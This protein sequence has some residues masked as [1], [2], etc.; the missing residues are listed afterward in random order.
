MELFLAPLDKVTNNWHYK[1][2]KS[3]LMVILTRLFNDFESARFLL[4][5]GFPEQAI[6]SMRDALECMMLFRLFS[7]DSKYAS[8]WSV[9]FKEYHI[10]I[11][12][13]FLD[14]LGVECPEYAFYGM[15]SEMVHPNLLSVASK[16]TEH[17]I[18]NTGMVR[19]YHFGGMNRP[20]WTT[21]VFNNLLVFILMTLLSVLSP[22]YATY[23]N[24]PE[25]W[26]SKVL[27]AR[28]KLKELKINIELEG[29]EESAE[30]KRVRKKVHQKLRLWRIEAEL[31]KMEFEQ[32]I[33][34]EDFS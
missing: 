32:I 20:T 12:K 5:N 14:E 26:W 1:E 30:E 9:Y 34:D 31:E 27:L 22:V 29:V 18:T 10:S 21:P 3:S 15:L 13:S 7:N 16:V 19:S 28:N 6:M 8:R 11:V 24:N 33:H 23:M 17:E 25:E 2:E 4:L